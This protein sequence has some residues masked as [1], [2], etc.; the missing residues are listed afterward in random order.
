MAENADHLWKA[1]HSY[2]GIPNCCAV[3]H[4]TPTSRACFPNI[5]T[6]QNLA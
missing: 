2:M 4:F 3:D 1:N 5:T 6:D